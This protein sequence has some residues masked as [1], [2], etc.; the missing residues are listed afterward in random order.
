M[1]IFLKTELIRNRSEAWIKNIRFSFPMVCRR[2]GKMLL[3]ADLLDVGLTQY[4]E[5]KE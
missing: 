1:R 4:K 2:D 3:P 5:D